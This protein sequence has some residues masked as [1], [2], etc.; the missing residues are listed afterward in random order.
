[1]AM[2]GLVL[3]ET[4]LHCPGLRLTWR[5]PGPL[6]AVAPVAAFSLPF[7]RIEARVPRPGIAAIVRHTTIRV[8]DVT[9][10]A[11]GSIASGQR[12]RRR[13]AGQ[14]PLAGY[15]HGGVARLE[16]VTNRHRVKWLTFWR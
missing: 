6:A 2:A 5:F 7:S 11:F 15:F 16:A 3:G 4:P 8:V 10:L 12:Q 1:M 14:K 9:A 13:L